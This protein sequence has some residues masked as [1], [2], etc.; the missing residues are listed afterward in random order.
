MKVTQPADAPGPKTSGRHRYL[1][2]VFLVWFAGIVGL[3]AVPRTEPEVNV[4]HWANGHL[5]DSSDL[6]PKFASAFNKREVETRSGG[7]IRVK[8]FKANSGQI[9]GE[10]KE[11]VSHG[12]AVDRGKPDPTIVTPAAEH[13]VNDVNSMVGQQVLDRENAETIATSYI[14]I[15]TSREMAQC[16]GWPQREIGF[17]DIEAL[18]TDTLGWSRYACARPEWGR[19]ALIAFTYP[20]RSS[21]ARS[22]LYALYAI[23]AGKA[24]EQ[25]TLADVTKAE[26]ADRIKRFQSAIDCYV[27]DTL[28]LNNKILSATPCAHFYFLAEDNLVQ[29]YQGKVEPLSGGTAK[30]LERDMVMIYAKEGSIVHNHSAFIVKAGFVSEDQAEAARRWI[31]FLREGNQ[32]QALMQAGFRPSV[33]PNCVDPLGSPFSQCAVTPKALISPSRISPDV[34]AAILKA[35]D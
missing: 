34:A 23:T 28:E 3:L 2:L 10:L 9:T 35:W 11:R 33:A 1:S 21:T 5:I 30:N 13:W 15:V 14:G 19:E 6:L 18:A 12:L 24:P 31:A 22:V 7:A 25:L 27:P 4:T 8:L 29:M 16:L 20:S 26:V 32:Q 17:A